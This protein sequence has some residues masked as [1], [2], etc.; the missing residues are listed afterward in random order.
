MSPIDEKMREN[1]LRWFGQVERR[2]INAPM[3]KTE[4]IQVEGTTKSRGRK[5]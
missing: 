1:G 4:L 3:R 5:T 2:V